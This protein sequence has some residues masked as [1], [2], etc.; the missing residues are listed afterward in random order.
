M[1]PWAY[2]IGTQRVEADRIL[3]NFV[4]HQNP[5]Y[6][7]AM[8]I[9]RNYGNVC[10]TLEQISAIDREYHDAISTVSRNCNTDDANTCLNRMGRQVRFPGF[11]S[12]SSPLS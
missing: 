9:I 12:S 6:V 8:G 1:R 5:V 10:A 2:E 4:L 7:A 3:K 11:A